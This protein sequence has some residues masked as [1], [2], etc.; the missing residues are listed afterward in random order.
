MNGGKGQPSI[1]MRRVP[2]GTKQSSKTS[3]HVSL[4][5]IPNLSNFWWV[6]KPVKPFSMMN[7]VIPFDPLS[8]S[9]FA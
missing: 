9:V 2:S 6:E 3:S 8:G 4:P 5:R 1:A 7:A